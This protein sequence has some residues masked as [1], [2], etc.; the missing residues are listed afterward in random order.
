MEEG[1]KREKTKPTC[2]CTW[3]RFVHDTVTE[4]LGPHSVWLPFGLPL[5][6]SAYNLSELQQALGTIHRQT[7]QLQLALSLT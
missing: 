4:L 7:M 5:V 3:N 6:S 2:T 1:R